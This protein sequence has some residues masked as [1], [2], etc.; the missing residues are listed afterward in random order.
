M[1]ITTYSDYS[2][3]LLMLLAIEEERLVTISEVAEA[4]DISRAHI[5]KVAHQLGIAGLVETVRGRSGG[6]RLAKPPEVIRIGEVLRL[7]EPDFDMVPCFEAPDMCRITSGCLLKNALGE[8]T[9][10]YLGVLDRYTLADLVADQRALKAL[11]AV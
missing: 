9:S 1:R 5:M 2:L 4:Y 6:L 10:A 8:A 3:R 11:L 7:T